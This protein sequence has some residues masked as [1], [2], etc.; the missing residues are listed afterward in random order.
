MSKLYKNENWLIQKYRTEKLTDKRISKLIKVSPPTI[1]NWRKKFHITTRSRGE[2]SHLAKGN[3]CSLSQEAIEWINGELLGDGCLVSQSSYSACFVYGSK[4]P[5]YV[6][7]I[8]KTLDSFGIKQC[9]K[10]Y[11]AHNKK[12]GCYYYCYAS[13][14][15]AEL[16]LLRNTWYPNGKKIVPRD[17][18]LTP[19]TVRQWYI[20]DGSL[21]NPRNAS[22]N[23]KL[24]TCG[25][26]VSDVKWLVEELIKLGFK[27]T[28][29]PSEN[30]IHISVYSIRD[31]LNYIGSCPVKDYKYKW[32]VRKEGV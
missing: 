27:A 6:K 15:Y 3:H 24:Y 29:Q 4:F 2:I 10:I 18:R 13:L 23:I 17:I 30:I 12:N 16:L 22:S 21:L 28:R 1:G 14:Y 7:Y 20:G 26:P 5:K 25:F 19:L 9:G 32:K 31:F 11:K 8:S